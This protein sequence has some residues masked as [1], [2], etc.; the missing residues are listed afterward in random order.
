MKILIIQ[1]KLIIYVLNLKAR[2]NLMDKCSIISKII[3]TLLKIAFPVKFELIMPIIT[4][5]G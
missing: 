2:G 5:R 1:Q 4:L 3:P